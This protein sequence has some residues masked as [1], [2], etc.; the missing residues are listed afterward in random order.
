MAVGHGQHVAII[1]QFRPGY[2]K[3]EV[4]KLVK[5]FKREFTL[6]SVLDTSFLW[7]AELYRKDVSTL[8]SVLDTSQ[9]L[10]LVYPAPT[11]ALNSVLDTSHSTGQGRCSK[12]PNLSIPSWILLS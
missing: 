9:H 2:F 7:F 4:K 5:K 12:R 1:S 11:P 6:N 8:N 10:Q 3:K